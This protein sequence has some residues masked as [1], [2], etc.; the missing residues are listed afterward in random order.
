MCVC[1]CVLMCV[2]THMLRQVFFIILTAGRNMQIFYFLC[3][4]NKD[5]YIICQSQEINS[6]D[7]FLDYAF[8]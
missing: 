4:E 7:T 3:S 5:S 8:I 2:C 1:V 6:L